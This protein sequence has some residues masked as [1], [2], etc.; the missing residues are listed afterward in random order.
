MLLHHVLKGR[1]TMATDYN[2]EAYYQKARS[3]EV[4]N[5]SSI[6][7]YIKS[8]GRVI[9]WGGSFQGKAIGK[10]LIKNGVKIDSYWDIR[11][12]ELK[13]VNG[14]PVVKP[15]STN[16]KEDTVVIVCIGN[17]VI[18]NGLIVTLERH[19]YHNY[20]HGDHLYMGLLCPFNKNTGVN[21]R[22]CSQTMECRQ[23][24][25]HRI[26]S[27]I[28]EQF[29]S[30]DPVYLPSITLV[31]NQVCSLGCK[32]CTS[33]MNLYPKAER[34]NFSLEQITSDIDKFFGAVD[35]VGTITVMGG[36]PFLHPNISDII[37]HLCA[38]KNF[39]LIS[40]ATSGTCPIKDSQ[41]DGL[42]DP[43]INISFSNYTE[44]I[45]GHRQK[46][47]WDNVAK[48]KAAGLC[49]TVG[50]F[51]PEWIIPS[52][53]ENKHISDEKARQ[54]K[55]ACTHWDQIKNG[56]VHPC[57]FANS[58]YSLGI[59]D[60]SDSYVD[61]NL[62]DDKDDLKEAI[63]AYREKDFYEVCRHHYQKPGMNIMVTKA[64]EQG[65]IDFTKPLQKNDD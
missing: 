20:I 56:K 61:L 55:Q 2:L 13:E 19:G 5:D 39:G 43:R 21:A 31:I 59:A 6:I 1:D 65:Y 34:I 10:S 9:L 46:Y 62:Y 11:C 8:F 22:R 28:S 45:D 63:R 64:A 50:L 29:H 48:I 26:M 54:L 57:D 30:D 41:L 15:Y 40:I 53:L 38:W 60:Y 4:C 35:A 16:D 52:T 49:H 33:Y 12:D 58:V 32:Y 51:S 47:F 36:E 7:P 27:I 17:R 3:G 14:I 44:S 42:T 37:K 18:Y 24:Y 23:I 25:C